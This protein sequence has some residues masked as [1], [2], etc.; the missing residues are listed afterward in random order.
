MTYYKILKSQSFFHRMKKDIYRKHRLF[1]NNISGDRILRESAI[2]SRF[3][4]KLQS[5]S[6]FPVF[7]AGEVVGVFREKVHRPKEKFFCCT[8]GS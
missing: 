4:R 7:F 8:K 2:Y 1:I 5:T 6:F 3:L